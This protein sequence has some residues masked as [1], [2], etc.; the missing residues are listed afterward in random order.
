MERRIHRFDFGNLRDFRGP[1]V[2]QTVR[3]VVE[4]APPPPPPP[5]TF[6]EQDLESARLAGRKQGYTEGFNAGKTE[7][8]REF[9]RATDAGNAI[10]SQL[11]GMVSGLQS[12]YRQILVAESANLSDLTLSIAKKVAGDALDS[13]GAEAIAAIIERCMPVILSKPKLI[14]ELHPDHFEQLLTRIETQLQTEGFEGEVQFKSNPNLG[15]GDVHLDWHSG[16]VHRSAEALWEEINT[17]IQRVPLE[18]TFA[19]TLD[20]KPTGE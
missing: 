1:I 19:E 2:M 11:G 20:T 4:E 16:N 8:Q 13:R 3:D 7:A 5:P 15:P 12:R 6:S 14:I 18:M 17:L 10:I 9:D